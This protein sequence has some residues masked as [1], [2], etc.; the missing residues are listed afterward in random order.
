MFCRDPASCTFLGQRDILQNMGSRFHSGRKATFLSRPLRA[1][2]SLL[3]TSSGL[4]QDIL[5]AASQRLGWAALL[6]AGTYAVAF[7]I[8][9]FSRAH[10]S[11]DSSVTDAIGISS[12]LSSVAVWWIVRNRF[13]NPS[14]LL[15]L[16]LVY[17]VVGALG[18]DLPR[19]YLNFVL[20]ANLDNA[21]LSWVCVWLVV[22][23]LVVPSSSGK[24]LIAALA[25]ASMGPL[26][27]LVVSRMFVPPQG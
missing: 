24:V 17:W 26:S 10:P 21:G 7:L 2:A 9:R 6:Y 25:T 13:F 20:G 14:R 5:D 16:G 8:D 11:I 23:P 27:F 15:N 3:F 19:Y 1:P 18:I 22:F 12:I 4:P